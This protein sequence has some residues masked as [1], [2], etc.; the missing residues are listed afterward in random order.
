MVCDAVYKQ[1]ADAS[2]ELEPWRTRNEIDPQA[3]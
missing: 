1:R 3:I 2:E